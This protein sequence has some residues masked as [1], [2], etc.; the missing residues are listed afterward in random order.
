MTIEV[1]ATIEQARAARNKL[2]VSNRMERLDPY[3]VNFDVH[4]TDVD[5]LT[6]VLDDL[7]LSWRLV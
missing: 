1:M 6:D 7:G 4:D 3:T 5:C 2:Q